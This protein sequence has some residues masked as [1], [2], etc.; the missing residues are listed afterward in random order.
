M[1]GLH[2][3]CSVDAMNSLLNILVK[4]EHI[5]LPLTK[6]NLVHTFQRKIILESIES[7]DPECPGE[8]FYFG[9][10]NQ[11]NNLNYDFLKSYTYTKKWFDVGIDG[12]S[13]IFKASPFELWPILI[14]FNGMKKIPPII[15]AAYW[16]KGEP[17]SSNEFLKKFVDEINVLKNQGRIVV[18]QKNH[19]IK[20]F[21]IHHFGCDAPAKSFIKNV[22]GHTGHNS[23]NF[24]NATVEEIT[25]G[26]ENGEIRKI[27]ISRIHNFTDDLQA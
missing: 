14:A 8:F 25:I 27:N 13:S 21:G 19:L 23:C 26:L 2:C 15:V 20:D 17:R 3:G 24:C 9:I 11:V 18:D 12:I 22:Q 16:G 1:W 5:N 4:K 10:Q 7:G 6:K